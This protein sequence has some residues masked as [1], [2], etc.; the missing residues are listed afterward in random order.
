MRILPENI[1]RAISRTAI[2]DDVFKIFIILR[3]HTL[4]AIANELTAIESRRNDRN[5]WSFFY[6]IPIRFSH[7]SAT[8]SALAA[9]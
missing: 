1:D 7:G 3:K 5:F 4:N 9:T 6:L 2:H 8:N